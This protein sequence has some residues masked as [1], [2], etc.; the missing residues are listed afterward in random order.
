MRENGRRS[1]CLGRMGAGTH[2]SGGE[3]LLPLVVW[4]SACATAPV[5]PH[6]SEGAGSVGETVSAEAGSAEPGEAASAAEASAGD[7]APGTGREGPPSGGGDGPVTR[8]VSEGA[9]RVDAGPWGFWVERTLFTSRWPTVLDAVRVDTSDGE[10]VYVAIVEDRG[11][12]R[13]YRLRIEPDGRGK[14]LDE[15]VSPSVHHQ[16]ATSPDGRLEAYVERQDGEVRLVVADRVARTETVVLRAPDEGDWSI[17][18]VAW[19]PDGSAVYFDNQGPAACIWRYDVKAGRLEKVVPAD[20]ARAPFPF[21][22]DR[23]EHVAFVELTEDGVSCLKLTRNLGRDARRAYVLGN[24]TLDSLNGE[25]VG[26]TAHEAGWR[27]RSWCG[28]AGRRL[29]V[30][31][32]AGT[33]RVGFG[34]DEQVFDV[35]AAVP[36]GRD[37]VAVLSREVSG[38]YVEVA[39]FRFL[40]EARTLAEVTCYAC[41]GAEPSRFVRADH[42]DGYPTLEEPCP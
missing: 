21:T 8:M 26:L 15:P 33:L 30:D 41:V 5:V 27:V 25:W 35:T 9:A 4:L 20:S 38:A 24:V 1:T 17:D 40:D 34:Q 36:T 37:T 14:V 32:S 19:S 29:L 7:S 12:G 28:T 18:G 13:R 6:T 23:I 39:A 42:R 10:A 2:H 31:A 16:R 11:T 3:I 22:L